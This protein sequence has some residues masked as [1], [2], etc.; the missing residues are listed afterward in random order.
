MNDLIS[1]SDDDDDS[2]F[3]LSL[4]DDESLDD[5]GLNISRMELNGFLLLVICNDELVLVRVME[6]LASTACRPLL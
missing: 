3:L 5:D 1:C 6:L 2:F 4:F